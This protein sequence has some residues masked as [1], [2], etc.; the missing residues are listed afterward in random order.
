MLGRLGMTVDECLDKYENL[1][2]RVFKHPRT[3]HIRRLLWPRSK[4]DATLLEGII[5][6]IVSEYEPSGLTESN[7]P[8]KYAHMCRT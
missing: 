8:Q 2:H 6:G 7:Y 1:A 4:Y 5:K 3:I